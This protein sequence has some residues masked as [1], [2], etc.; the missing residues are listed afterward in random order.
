M[1]SLE[2]NKKLFLVFYKMLN[3]KYMVEIFDVNEVISKEKVVKMFLV[4]VMMWYLKCL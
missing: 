1:S 4:Y 3:V 2:K